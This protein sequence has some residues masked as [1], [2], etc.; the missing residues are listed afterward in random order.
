MFIAVSECHQHCQKI[1]TYFLNFH[2]VELV[3]AKKLLV[4]V[5]PYF[6]ATFFS[7]IHAARTT[8]IKLQ[9]TADK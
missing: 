8:R 2:A 9:E 7:F 3:I 5:F 4:C 1:F 6:H